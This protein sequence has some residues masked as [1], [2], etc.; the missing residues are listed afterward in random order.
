MEPLL[1]HKTSPDARAV[2]CIESVD[3]EQGRKAAMADPEISSIL[4]NIFKVF[5]LTVRRINRHQIF[6][7]WQQAFCQVQRHKQGIILCPN[8]QVTGDLAEEL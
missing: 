4:A 6:H 7:R 2:A 8:V 1:T 5:R 3:L